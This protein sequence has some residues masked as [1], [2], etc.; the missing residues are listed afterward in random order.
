M[1][2]L[3]KHVEEDCEWACKAIIAKRIKGPAVYKILLQRLGVT[4]SNVSSKTRKKSP[5]RK[6]IICT[7]ILSNCAR[8]T[9]RSE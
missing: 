9:L 6:K 3:F 1:C 5:Q 4:L 7:A 2:W 8:F